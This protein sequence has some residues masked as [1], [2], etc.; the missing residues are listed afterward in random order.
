MLPILVDAEASKIREGSM[1]VVKGFS[2]INSL[3]ITFIIMT[4]AFSFGR[5]FVASMAFLITLSKMI[6][7]YFGGEAI[8][9]FFGI[10]FFI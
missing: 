4:L 2:I 7:K 8:V 10:S 1:L 6:F 9:K 5:S 3:S